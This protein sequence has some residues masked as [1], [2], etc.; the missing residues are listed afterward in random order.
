MSDEYLVQRAVAMTR[1]SVLRIEDGCDA[2]VYGCEGSLW[3]QRAGSAVVEE[4][5]SGAGDRASF[6][7]RLRRLW[8]SL[9]APHSRPTGATL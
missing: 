4:L 2:L 1:G 3:L 8:A 7:A 9:F 6:G 5:Y